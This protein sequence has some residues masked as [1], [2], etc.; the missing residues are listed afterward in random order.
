[1]SGSKPLDV[2]PGN[3]TVSKSASSS[4]M[5]DR[6][7]KFNALTPAGPRSRRNS[8][9]DTK[10]DPT[11]QQPIDPTHGATLAPANSPASPSGTTTPMTPPGV[12]S[13]PFPGASAPPGPAGPVAP[14]IQLPP[15]TATSTATPAVA[16]P[17]ATPSLAPTSLTAETPTTASLRNDAD[18]FTPFLIGSNKRHFHVHTQVLL[19]KCPY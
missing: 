16:T 15:T 2:P 6:I 11:P 8:D 14:A 1:M 3:K 13:A 17:A 10:T 5:R 4:S 18:N 7:E 19:E 9:T 12:V